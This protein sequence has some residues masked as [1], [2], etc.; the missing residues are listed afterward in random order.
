M[1]DNWAPGWQYKRIGFY[2]AHLRRYYERFGRDQIRVYLYEDLKADAAGVM[3]DLYG[4]LGV[5]EEFAPDTSLKYN[6]AGVPR[7]GAARALVRNLNSLTPFLK[8]A[9]PFG[10][11]QRI[12]GGLFAEPPPLAAE[13]RRGLVEEYREDILKL[14]GL[15][16]RDLSGWLEA[17]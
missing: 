1:R 7:N 14:Q 3:R 16:G 9:L 12:K 5:D 17:G 11:R 4:F 13:A 6:R 15:I 2:H 10:V 8:G